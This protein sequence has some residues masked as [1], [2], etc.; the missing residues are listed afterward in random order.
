MGDLTKNLSRREMACRCD[1][2]FDTVDIGLAEILQNAV[3][4]F[5]REYNC[6]ITL[7]IKGGNRCAKRN[8]ETK[9][10]AKNSQHIQARAADHQLFLSDGGQIPPKKVADYYSSTYPGEYGIGRY[11]NRTHIDNRSGKCARWGRD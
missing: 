6:R 5:E 8:E 11:S 1:C 9:G 4:H 10:A 3:D 7:R 2:G